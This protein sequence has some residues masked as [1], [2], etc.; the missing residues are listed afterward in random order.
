MQDSSFSNQTRDDP[1]YSTLR[2]IGQHGS[3]VSSDLRKTIKRSA[4][5]K[6]ALRSLEQEMF[7]NP[8]YKHLVGTTQAID[9]IQGG[10]KTNALPEQAW[11]VVNHRIAVIRSVGNQLGFLFIID[12]DNSSVG[13]VKAHD[14]NL[15]KSLAKDFNLTYEAFGKKLTLDDTTSSGT[16]TLSNA[17]QSHLEPA[18]VTP[19]GKDAAPYQLLS[20]TIKAT[21]N[22]HR[23]LQG[24]DTIT[25]A[26][27]M[28]SGNTGV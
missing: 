14:S 16:L 3:D 22:S 2:C 24:G 23:S 21:Y 27:G 19:T 26:P 13:E 8:V 25:V 4:K 5:S 15:L 1:F 18:P 17:F 12:K 10:V 6:K 7:K 11:A 9:L 20:G 28:P